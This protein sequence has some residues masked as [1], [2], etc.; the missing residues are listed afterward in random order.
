MAKINYFEPNGCNNEIPSNEDIN[1]Y[2]S[3]ETTTK[4][5][6]LV[7]VNNIE[8]DTIINSGGKTTT[9]KFLNSTK[10]SDNSL[11]TSYTDVT[12]L[13]GDEEDI[14]TLGIESID[15]DF[16][17]AYTPLIKIKFIDLRG[18]SIIG[19][20][21]KSKYK[22][23]FDLPYPIFSLTV[24][25][26]YGKPVKYCLHL[27]KWNAKFNSKTGNFEIETEFIGYTYAIL[28]DLLLGYL[29]AVELTEEGSIIFQQKQEEF[30][31]STDG[32]TL[33]SING[34][35]KVIGEL[36][37]SFNKI[38]NDDKNVDS[39]KNIEKVEAG[40]DGL[41]NKYRLLKNTLIPPDT[42]YFFDKGVIVV[43][44]NDKKGINYTKEIE[45]FNEDI[46]ID[47]EKYNESLK[48]TD[49]CFNFV[50]NEELIKQPFSGYTGTSDDIEEALFATS[51]YDI[52]EKKSKDPVVKDSTRLLSKIL[53][54]NFPIN[55]IG[56]FDLY[57]FR[58]LLRE[59]NVVT[60]EL[61][62]KKKEYRS[63][64]ASDL[65]V[66][67]RDKF[68]F[69]PTIRNIFRS[70]TIHCEVLL[71][72]IKKVSKDAAD[73]EIRE[74]ILKRELGE[75]SINKEKDRDIYPWPEVRRKDGGDED[76]Y[77]ESWIGKGFSINDKQGVHEIKFVEDILAQ[78]MLLS[79]QDTEA[80]LAKNYNGEQYYPISPLD[81]IFFNKEN[82]NPYNTAL[83][84]DVGTT[85][86]PNEATRCLMMR[87]FLGLGVSST[88]LPKNL[89]ESMGALE[90]YN[91]YNAVTK[92]ATTDKANA[93]LSNILRDEEGAKNTS[94]KLISKWKDGF[95]N[96]KNPRGVITPLLKENGDLYHYVYINDPT[97]NSTTINNRVF[98]PING[99]FDGRAFYNSAGNAYKSDTELKELN[100]KDGFNFTSNNFG[101]KQNIDNYEQSTT[102]DSPDGSNYFQILV[103]QQYK[104][105]ATRPSYG[106]LY[107]SEVYNKKLENKGILSQD[108]LRRNTYQKPTDGTTNS[109][110]KRMVGLNPLNSNLL[111]EEI[112]EIKYDIAKYD[113]GSD[114]TYNSDKG[115][116]S[117][118]CSYWDN[119]YV[120]SRNRI[121]GT[122]LAYSSF[123]EETDGGNTMVNKKEYLTNEYQILDN[124]N[125]L[126][127]RGK[128][129]YE[130]ELGIAGIYN[131]HSEI[132]LF[133]KQR[134][135]LGDI[136]DDIPEKTNIS[137]GQPIYLPYIEFGITTFN[138]L[139]GIIDRNNANYYSLFGSEFY[140]NQ[141]TVEAKAFLFLHSLGWHGLVGYN[142]GDES[143]LFDLFKVEGR[144][145]NGITVYDRPYTEDETPTI[146]SIFKNN[147][148]FIK[149]PKLWCAF[150][151]GLLYRHKQTTD[152]ISFTGS[153]GEPVLPFQQIGSYVPS[154]NHHL[155][156]TRGDSSFGINFHFDAGAGATDEGDESYHPID[157]TLLNLPIQ[158]KNEFIQ[159]FIN[160]TTPDINQTESEFDIIRNGL[161]LF[162]SPSDLKTKWETMR[163]D[164]SIIDTGFGLR[165]IRNSNIRNILGVDIS[166]YT[167]ISPG[168]GVGDIR[169]FNL[170][171][172]ADT[173]V[174]NRIVNNIGTTY[175]ILNGSPKTFR[176][177]DPNFVD[178][179]VYDELSVRG[180]ELTTYLDNFFETLDKLFNDKLANN[181]AEN[182]AIQKE[183]FNS[184]DDDMIKLNIYRTIG[185]IYTKWIAGSD[186]ILNQCG[187]NKSRSL[188]DT[189]KFLD[190]GFND[191]GDEFYINP[192]AVRDL[193]INN[194]N[195][196]FF[197]VIDR[198][199]ADN[200]FNF[201][202]LPTFLDFTKED[203]LKSMFT[204]YSY[205]DLDENDF[206]SG[207]SF[208]CTY[209]GQ[210]SANLDLGV[211]GNYKDDGIVI[212]LN[213][214]CTIDE[215]D[216]PSDFVNVPMIGVSY[217]KQNQ[218]FFKDIRLDQT[219]FSETSES[220]QIIEDIS[221]NGD[222]RKSSYVGQNLFNVYQTRSYSAEV[223]M[224]GCA[225]MQ[226]MIYFHLNNIPMFRGAYM[227]LKVSHRITANNMTTKFKGVRIKRTK[228]PLITA[229]ALFMNLLGSFKTLEGTSNRIRRN[230]D[231]GAVDIVNV[232]DE[233]L[234]N[235]Y[236]AE[237]GGIYIVDKSNGLAGETLREFMGELSN[238]LSTELDDKNIELASN[239]VT[240]NLQE[241]M[242]G[243]SGRSTKSKHGAG[244]AIDVV[245][246]GDY[247]GV[248]LGN[249]Y[250]KSD[251]RTPYGWVAG[252]VT[253]VKDDAVMTKIKEFLTTNTKWSDLI[254]WGGDFKGYGKVGR[255][256][257]IST[258]STI[259]NFSVR[260]DEIHHFEIKDDK[261]AAYFTKYNDELTELGLS[262][263]KNSNGLVSI[264]QKPFTFTDG[265]RVANQKLKE[266]DAENDEIGQNLG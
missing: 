253:V 259:P 175:V 147:A 151:G 249:P 95:S 28:T 123:S 169:Q 199:L 48:P 170:T 98:L 120:S 161:E 101:T 207:P 47:I 241:V 160:F 129:R 4:G 182:D 239:G 197:D 157:K 265:D 237:A 19:K 215:N 10:N 27:L 45:K 77:V 189:F 14:E 191:I 229:E 224:M 52:S 40:I 97:N 226:P 111:V 206:D 220:L 208:I 9:L 144:N 104:N 260:V 179:D 70:F 29:R 69:D 90:A 44:N 125:S 146:K 173:P 67:S 205:N 21:N 2:V 112:S 201:I 74:V 78:L 82:I 103:N 256:N 43:P 140:Y 58:S 266:G 204:P 213:D 57:D 174:N 13:L 158:I 193:L 183:I 232:R 15:I 238:Y 165:K 53:H 214:N 121:G 56:D 96:I 180:V 31:N 68:N 119:M 209:A 94:A 263:P 109:N 216:G 217:A 184:I 128:N 105:E 203:D 124:N 150:I 230:E 218:S 190:R 72:T 257:I 88:K 127:G 132:H 159:I 228:T 188:L 221:T 100:T 32:G 55:G 122:Y 130:K 106:G 138:I 37:E 5:N 26:H 171:L 246:S 194:L 20:G 80:V 42:D 240:R 108:T 222:K 236:I 225:M 181:D 63:N 245:Y 75:K 148:A 83:T 177:V 133:G 41:I 115:V 244:L 163:I 61:K 137:N 59:I 3:L 142:V 66:L 134:E 7:M 23:F 154:K 92:N 17:T 81:T 242:V 162:T 38:K 248:T 24:K 36:D 102:S 6:S 255:A 91:L 25:G 116:A 99:N 34:L 254:K 202:A 139:Q 196:S 176:D 12:S 54:K 227:I 210:T 84:N 233:L 93:L 135:L 185:S 235:F 114:I 71:E 62:I 168:N 118:L 243:G 16:D 234:G 141:T 86:N 198:I 39:I 195:V 153:T 149:A 35:I 60:E 64:I 113:T 143:S 192:F 1:I 110:A 131:P 49:V 107:I 76:E 223:E 261:M 258:V 247:S 152:I 187:N 155:F 211:D 18:A 50:K 167:N 251:T 85:Y 46:S 11:T 172:K 117:I 156:D 51:V 33:L 186:T 262:A 89:I 250:D 73:S 126:L 231:S 212:E 145:E 252:N 8:G 219:E 65:L 164:N 178:G 264:Y 22:M 30:A 79:K 87:G 166:N 136:L 200:N